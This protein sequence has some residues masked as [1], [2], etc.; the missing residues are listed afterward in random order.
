MI[1]GGAEFP[2]PPFHLSDFC[3]HHRR[4]RLDKWP[5]PGIKPKT[6]ESPLYG[7]ILRQL[8]P[9]G[10]TGRIMTWLKESWTIMEKD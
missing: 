7:A 8:E 1:V 2:L 4:P 5:L 10:S 9:I 6:P 3:A